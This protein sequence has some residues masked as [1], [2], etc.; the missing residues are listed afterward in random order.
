MKRETLKY[1]EE[2]KKNGRVGTKIIN[3][4]HS[5]DDPLIKS[6]DKINKLLE[7]L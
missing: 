1:I 7:K 2:I 3:L 5:K 6:R 4:S